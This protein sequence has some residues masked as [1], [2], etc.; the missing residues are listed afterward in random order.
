[1]ALKHILNRLNPRD[2]EIIHAPA[3][4]PVHDFGKEGDYVE[5]HVYDINDNYLDSNIIG[6]FM[7]D[8]QLKLKPGN[9][10][11][12]MGFSEGKYKV[13]YNFL[14]KVGGSEETVLVNGLKSFSGVLR[15]E[16]ML[17]MMIV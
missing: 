6:D 4:V 7:V 9:D 3:P 5:L 15:A 8:G 13:D 10:L 1:M 14:R 12:D 17:T 16:Q 2:A 11:R